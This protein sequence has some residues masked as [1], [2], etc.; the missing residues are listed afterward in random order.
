MVHFAANKVSKFDHTNVTNA[1]ES[2]RVAI[3]TLK[4]DMAPIV[5]SFLKRKATANNSLSCL[6]DQQ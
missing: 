2:E 3:T 1:C 5:D 4:T 6:N